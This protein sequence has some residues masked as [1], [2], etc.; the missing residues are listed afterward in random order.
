MSFQSGLW[1]G[2]GTQGLFSYLNVLLNSF[3]FLTL[4]SPLFF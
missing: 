3:G 4:S 2:V 1:L